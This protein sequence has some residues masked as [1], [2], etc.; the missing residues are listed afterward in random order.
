MPTYFM[1]SAYFMHAV[2]A[3]RA[4]W[5]PQGVNFG[6]TPNEGMAMIVILSVFLIVGVLAA[7]MRP[8]RAQ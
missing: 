8:S 5:L 2:H 1:H 7:A 3:P 6:F 4:K